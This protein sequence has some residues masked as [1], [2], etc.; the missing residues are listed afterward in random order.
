M[1]VSA[2]MCPRISKGF[3][4][5]ELRELGEQRFQEEYNLAFIEDGD[6][7]IRDEFFNRAISKDV[8]RLWQ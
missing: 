4:E 8:C 1:R 7:V 3:L 5:E 2:E 6:Q